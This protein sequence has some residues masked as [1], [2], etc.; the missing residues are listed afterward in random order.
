[1]YCCED[2]SRGIPCKCGERMTLED[3]YRSSSTSTSTITVYS[4]G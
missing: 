4:I 2:C 1:V 3:N